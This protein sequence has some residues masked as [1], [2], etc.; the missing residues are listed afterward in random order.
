LDFVLSQFPDG[1]EK[2][3]SAFGGEELWGI[4]LI[5]FILAH[6]F[7]VFALYGNSCGAEVDEKT[8]VFLQPI[9][10]IYYLYFMGLG[11]LFYRFEFN[12]DFIFYQYIN[13]KV[14]RPLNFPYNE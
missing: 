8:D 3:Q 6:S 4:W 7:S 9:E 2:Y 1:I 14:S 12:D 11:Y 13:G 5:V 10:I